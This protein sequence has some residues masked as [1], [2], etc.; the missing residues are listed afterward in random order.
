MLDGF[1]GEQV[2]VLI[3]Q[4]GASI[5]A[6]VG[7]AGVL[8]HADPIPIAGLREEVG[9]SRRARFFYVGDA[10]GDSTWFLIQEAGFRAGRIDLASDDDTSIHIHSDTLQLMVTGPAAGGAQS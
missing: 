3:G 2:T 1:L 4:P 9:R 6:F 10:N 8:Q 7:F 5:A